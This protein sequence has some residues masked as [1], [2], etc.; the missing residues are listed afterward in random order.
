M[1]TV[2]E[3]QNTYNSEQSRMLSEARSILGEHDL[4]RYQELYDLLRDGPG[5]EVFEY[6]FQTGIKRWRACKTTAWSRRFEHVYTAFEERGH[7]VA[8]ELVLERASSNRDLQNRLDTLFKRQRQQD[9]PLEGRIWNIVL[10]IED[11]SRRQIALGAVV[12]RVP[13]VTDLDGD[14]FELIETGDLV[15]VDADAGV[16]TITKR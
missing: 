9:K 3:Q 7:A 4:A 13:T 2:S 14:V 15:E 6:V 5:D 10:A 1:S 12:S 8:I 16:V 11:T